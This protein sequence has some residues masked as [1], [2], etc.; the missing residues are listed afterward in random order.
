MEISFKKVPNFQKANITPLAVCIHIGEGS[1]DIIYQTFLTEEKSSH[2]IIGEK[3]IWQCVAEKDK[4]WAQ[5]NVIR[6]THSL[7]L[8]NPDKNPNEY[9]LSVENAGYAYQDIPEWQY[10]QNA[11][12]YENICLRYNWPVD[13]AHILRHREINADKTCPGKIDLDK[14]VRYAQQLRAEKE[15]PIEVKAVVFTSPDFNKIKKQIGILQKIMLL[16]KQIFDLKKK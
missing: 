16:L 15:K 12:L 14:I 2:Y 5:G 13:R 4:A 11:E 3:G 7:V 6:P 8:N 10:W 9:L 1:Q